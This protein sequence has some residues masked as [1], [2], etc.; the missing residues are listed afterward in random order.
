VFERTRAIDLTLPPSTTTVLTLKLRTPATPYWSRP[1][2]GISREDVSVQGREVHVRVHSLG[3]VPSPETVV[4]FRQAGRI[5][6]TAVVP[7]LDAP[8]DLQPKATEVALTL[9]VGT[10]PEG[11]VVEIDP[12]HTLQEI[13]VLNN[14]VEL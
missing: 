4:A 7:A 1:D 14:R 8:L 13:T 9:P 2:L 10:D 11:G 3:S 6:A 5:M 12:E